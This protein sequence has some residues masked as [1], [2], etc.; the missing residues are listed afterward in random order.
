MKSVF[1]D[2]IF[3]DKKLKEDMKYQEVFSEYAESNVVIRFKRGS[4]GFA[5]MKGAFYGYNKEAAKE[6]VCNKIN[7]GR[8]EF[9]KICTKLN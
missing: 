8:S 1:I 5:G 3:A 9:L 6:N 4:T 7:I 2:S